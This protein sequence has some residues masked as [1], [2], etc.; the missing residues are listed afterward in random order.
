MAGPL[1]R[2][3]TSLPHPR[4]GCTRL[5][6]RSDTFDGKQRTLYIKG[7]YPHVTLADARAQAV[8]ARKLIAEGIDPNHAK[9]RLL[10]ENAAVTT[11]GELAEDWFKDTVS[12]PTVAKENQKD[13]EGVKTQRLRM[14]VLIGALGHRGPTTIEP[15][16]VLAAIKSKR[17]K[18]HGHTA[19]RIMSMA[20]WIDSGLLL[21]P[22]R[23]QAELQDANHATQIG[24][25]I[26]ST[27]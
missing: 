16:D 1:S 6:R 12:G 9:K 13:E 2:P 15:A 20:S 25:H 5:W 10:R 17:E 4:R 22:C 11:F 3:T 18:G 24:S 14:N 19:K 21:P 26:C 27:I 8:A 7:K 23:R